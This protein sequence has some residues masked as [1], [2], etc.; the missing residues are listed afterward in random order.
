MSR[1]QAKFGGSWSC[2]TWADGQGD[3]DVVAKL[4]QSMRL[5][6]RGQ[7]FQISEAR[8]SLVLPIVIERDDVEL[9]VDSLQG[10]D[11]T[12]DDLIEIMISMLA[13][14]ATIEEC[15]IFARAKIAELSSDQNW[16][17]LVGIKGSFA[18]EESQNEQIENAPEVV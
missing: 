10:F 18:F 7:I 17:V 3:A 2:C 1:F 5:R 13:T 8:D 15:G 4:D 14:N 11:L 9:E 16:I 12:T 6:I